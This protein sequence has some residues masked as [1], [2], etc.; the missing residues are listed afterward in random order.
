MSRLWFCRTLLLDRWVSWAFSRVRRSSC[1][2][3]LESGPAGVWCGPPNTRPLRRVWFPTAPC[4]CLTPAVVSTWTAFSHLG[5]VSYTHTNINRPQT[6]IM[7]HFLMATLNHH[8]KLPLAVQWQVPLG[9]VIWNCNAISLLAGQYFDIL[10]EHVVVIWNYWCICVHL[11]IGWCFYPKCLTLHSRYAF[12]HFIHSMRTEP[13]PFVLLV[14]CS[15]VWANTFI[16]C[17]AFKIV[18]RI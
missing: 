13:K 14:P 5:K 3:G 7:C 9:D 12:D 16:K 8:P 2:R 4:Q 11:H 15:A 6:L 18:M 1:W 10:V 17:Y